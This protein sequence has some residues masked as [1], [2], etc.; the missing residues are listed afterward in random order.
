[1]AMTIASIAS[2]ASDGGGVDGL[3]DHSHRGQTVVRVAQDGRRVQQT[4]SGTA[5]SQAEGEEN[6]LKGGGKSWLLN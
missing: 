5:Q 4:G 6:E 1:M 2:I 3:V